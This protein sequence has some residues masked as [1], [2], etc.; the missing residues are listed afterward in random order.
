MDSQVANSQMNNSEFNILTSY[1]CSGASLFG[2]YMQVFDCESASDLP[3][4]RAS[5]C[6][7]SNQNPAEHNGIALNG[8]A[9]TA[10]QVYLDLSIS[11]AL[12]ILV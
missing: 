11:G 3:W 1:I 12:K 8:F 9:E 4:S 6:V 2:E 5:R 7:F 10:V